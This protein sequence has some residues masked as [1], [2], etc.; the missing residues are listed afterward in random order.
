MSEVEERMFLA[1]TGFGCG[2]VRVLVDL[3]GAQR[4]SSVDGG[5]GRSADVGL[6]GELGLV[7]AVVQGGRRQH[8]VAHA[9]RDLV[10]DAG[11]VAPVLDGVARRAL[12]RHQVGHGAG[13]AQ[14]GGGRVGVE[15]G[16]AGQVRGGQ[17]RVD[18][19]RVGG[20]V[21]MERVRRL[22]GDGGGDVGLLAPMAVSLSYH[23]LLG[24][25]EEMTAGCQLL[26]CLDSIVYGL[27]LLE[28]S[29][30]GE[31]WTVTQLMTFFRCFED[32]LE[33]PEGRKALCHVSTT[34][35]QTFYPCGNI[36]INNDKHTKQ[37]RIPPSKPRTDL[38]LCLWS[39]SSSV[40]LLM[41]MM[42]TAG[43]GVS[44]M[45]MVCLGTWCWCW[46]WCWWS[47]VVLEACSASPAPHPPPPQPCGGGQLE[48]EPFCSTA[49][50]GGVFSF[51]RLERCG[52]STA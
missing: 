17:V 32:E 45:T 2:R 14:G 22:S 23:V 51:T 10:D 27:L 11:R 35:L 42:L 38:L 43:L 36:R 44:G 25:E 41:V 37:N 13:G 33:E 16:L 48:A 49:Q 7:L 21:V 31:S 40:S 28:Q 46:C 6:V 9:D 19:A 50:R 30:L 15:V 4:V 18:V 47:R 34:S 29:E 8:A 1:P 39:S 24:L 12:R 52:D 3:G 20:A 5:G 26:G